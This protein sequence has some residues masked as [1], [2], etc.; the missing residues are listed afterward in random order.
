MCHCMGIVCQR[1]PRDSKLSR[2]KTCGAFR[3][4]ATPKT[5][6]RFGTCAVV[7]GV[8]AS[9]NSLGYGRDLPS[10]SEQ[11]GRMTM[12]WRADSAPIEAGGTYDR[13][14]R[15]LPERERLARQQPIHLAGCQVLALDIRRACADHL[16]DVKTKRHRCPLKQDHP[17][18]HSQLRPAIVVAG[19]RGALLVLRLY[20]CDSFARR[21][22]VRWA[23][24]L[25]YLLQTSFPGETSAMLMTGNNE[26][27]TIVNLREQAD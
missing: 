15:R 19:K 11:I 26:Q 25:A 3:D 10:H 13:K 22:R 2:R 8:A 21:D 17:T 7:L 20:A 27:L 18:G 1:N 4:A 5:V 24:R 9:G 6:R 12:R 23:K 14:S 16:K